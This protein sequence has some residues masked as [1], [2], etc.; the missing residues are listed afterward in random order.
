MSVKA[1]R[2]GNWGVIET[3]SGPVTA[4]VIRRIVNKLN[5]APAAASGTAIGGGGGGGGGGYGSSVHGPEHADGGSASQ[6]LGRD[7][8]GPFQFKWTN[9]HTFEMASP[10]RVPIT[11]KRMASQSGDFIFVTDES[12]T[13][14][15]RSASAL[16][17]RRAPRST[18]SGSRSTS[19]VVRARTPANCPPRSRT[20]SLGIAPRTSR[21]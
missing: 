4:Q 19:R 14:T 7:K 11:M 9:S 10:A 16:R 1:I 21:A 18:S 5:S 17:R 3:E 2:H 8:I 20:S 13:P 6:K 15:P 12:A